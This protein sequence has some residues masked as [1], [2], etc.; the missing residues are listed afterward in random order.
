MPF[1]RM[2]FLKS[3]RLILIRSTPG[4]RMPL[5]IVADEPMVLYRWF[6]VRALPAH[7]TA[8]KIASWYCLITDIDDR[9]RAEE[10]LSKARSELARVSR[11][12]TL[13]ALTASIAHEVNQP[14]SGIVTNA[15]ACLRMLAADPPDLEGACETARRTIRDGQRASDVVTRLRALFSKKSAPTEVVDLN[16]ST[17]EVIA[18]LSNEL[19]AA[20]V[21]LRVELA[22]DLPPV[23][24]DRVQLQQVVLNLMLNAS[25]AMRD[26]DVRPKRLTIKTHRD[27]EDGV[28]LCQPARKTDHLSASNFDQ[29]RTVI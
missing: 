16:E 9:K 8:G 26:I 17:E 25:E 22:R 2:T 20:G 27:A 28:H 13:G 12:T 6:Q 4:P 21:I 24:G 5:S 14:L 19:H 1:I 29:G 11:V 18:L 10:A 7:D 23:A 3:S 15:S